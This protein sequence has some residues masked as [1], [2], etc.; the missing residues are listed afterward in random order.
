MSQRLI[1]HC[2]PSIIWVKDADQTLV[3]DG[4]LGQSW[5]LRGAEAVTW[6]LLT[7][8]YS[9]REIAQVLSLIL[10]LS[11]EEAEHTLASVLR[12]WRYANIVQVSGEANDG[13]PDGQCGV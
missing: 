2:S 13:E 3:V 4:E 7:V 10:S 5:A 6:D 12:K 8:G 9:S 1:Y 11:V